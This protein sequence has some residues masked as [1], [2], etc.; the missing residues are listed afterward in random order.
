MI[1]M[2]SVI[3]LS[4]IDRHSTGCLLIESSTNMIKAFTYVVNDTKY[5]LF[6][7]RRQ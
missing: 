5:A 1:V 6:R 2:R 7:L 3:T 4:N